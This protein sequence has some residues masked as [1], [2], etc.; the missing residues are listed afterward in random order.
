MKR[1]WVVCSCV[2]FIVKQGNRCALLG[3]NFT[4]EGTWLQCS[5]QDKTC[6]Y[7]NL[8][9]TIQVVI[10]NTKFSNVHVILHKTRFA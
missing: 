8:V 5:I 2:C 6:R 7:T 10:G 1:C 4:T 9:L 3:Y